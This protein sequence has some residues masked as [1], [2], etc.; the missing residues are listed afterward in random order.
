MDGIFLALLQEGRR[1]VVFYLVTIFFAC[2]ATGCDPAIWRQVNVAFIPKTG[3]I[4]YSG[5]MDFRLTSL[6]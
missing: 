2:L 4:S 3:R 6:T 5:T 1:I